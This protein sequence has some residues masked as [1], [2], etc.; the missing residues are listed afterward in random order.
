MWVV[1]T[2]TRA[3]LASGTVSMKFRATCLSPKTGVTEIPVNEDQAAVSGQLNQQSGR[4]AAFVVT[5]NVISSGL[6]DPLIDAVFIRCSL[7]FNLPDIPLFYG[8]VSTLQDTQD[9]KVAA[10]CTGVAADVIKN[11]FITPHT[12]SGGSALI[13]LT[14]IIQDC[15]S[16]FSVTADSR[17]SQ[18]TAPVVPLTWETSRGQ[19][20]DDLANSLNAVWQ[21]DRTGGFVVY[22]NPYLLGNTPTDIFITDGVGGALVKVTHATTRETIYNSITVVVEDQSANVEPVRVTVQ[23]TNPL[24]PTRWGGPFGK[25]NQTVRLSGP[26]V[27]KSGALVYGQ[28]LLRQSLAKQDTWTVETPF[29]PLLDPGDIFTVNYLGMNHTLVAETVVNDGRAQ[30]TTRIAG[31]ELLQISED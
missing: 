6:L 16:S 22:L 29:M 19:A 23:D 28:R 27:D 17:V 1:D 2:T 7:G 26:T 10:T 15:D 12:S 18:N 20:L 25:R 30:T 24:S 8:R 9:G 31:R 4:N 3:A 5:R 14:H 21:E 11:D 13:D